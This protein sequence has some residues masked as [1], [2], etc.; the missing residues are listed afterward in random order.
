M[1]GIIFITS[2]LLGFMRLDAEEYQLRVPATFVPP[3]PTD[4][5][6]TP[7]RWRTSVYD[8]V[9]RGTLVLDDRQNDCFGGWKL[10]QLMDH[11]PLTP[12]CQHKP[13][14]PAG[15]LAEHFY[16]AKEFTGIACTPL[17]LLSGRR[18]YGEQLYKLVQMLSPSSLLGIK[19]VIVHFEGC[20]RCALQ[21][22][23]D[24][25]DQVGLC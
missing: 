2:I 15:D 21:L 11:V 20:I 6:Q 22:C 14:S 3:R 4:S 9:L 24:C 17:L 10:M 8:D 25:H 23:L 12:P 13:D 18:D 5:L 16:L 19:E 1:N 7:M